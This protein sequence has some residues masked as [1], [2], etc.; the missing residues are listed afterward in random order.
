MREVGGIVTMTS[1]VLGYPQETPET[2]AES[3]QLCYELQIYP[4]CGFLLPLPATE[5]WRYCV[6]NSYIDDPDKFLSEVTE[7]QDIILNLTRMSDEKLYNEVINGLASLSQAFDLGL[8]GGSLIRTGGMTKHG[9]NQDKIA[10]EDEKKL[11]TANLQADYV[12]ELNYSK[13]EGGM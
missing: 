12:P 5:M 6:E 10:E 3:M 2:I 7:R 8:K 4:S 9:K 13:M 11:V 1:L